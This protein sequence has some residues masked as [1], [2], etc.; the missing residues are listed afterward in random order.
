MLIE[1]TLEA[2][3]PQLLA[4]LDHLDYDEASQEASGT[5]ATNPNWAEREAWRFDRH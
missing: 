5:Q 2:L 3:H 1:K 4:V